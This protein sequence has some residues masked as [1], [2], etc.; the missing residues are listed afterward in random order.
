[1]AKTPTQIQND[2]DARRGLKVKG[3]KLELETIELI[4]QLAKQLSIPQN[5]LLKEAIEAYAKAKQ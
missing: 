5:A 2:S 3:F 4:E 1:M